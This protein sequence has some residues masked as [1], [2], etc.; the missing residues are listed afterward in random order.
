MQAVLESCTGQ[1]VSNGASLQ[2]ILSEPR[3][4]FALMLQ[5]LSTDENSRDDGTGILVEIEGDTDDAILCV[6]RSRI[7]LKPVTREESARLT[8]ASVLANDLRSNEGFL[9]CVAHQDEMSRG[10]NNIDTRL[11]RQR[12]IEYLEFDNRLR[13][14]PEIP[15]NL[16]DVSF[17]EESLW[18][19]VAAQL[20]GE[21]V[22]AE[23]KF[24]ESKKW[25][26][27]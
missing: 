2:E 20:G 8:F 21:L 10:P 4:T 14:L 25:C 12:C 5:H 17:D 24:P 11:A 16:R 3:R 26:L 6:R 1:P 9:S 27:Q 7:S 23:D 18:L 13:Q 22:I 15:D 19:I